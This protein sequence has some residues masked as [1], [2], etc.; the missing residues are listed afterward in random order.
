MGKKGIARVYRIVVESEV[1]DRYASAFEGMRMETRG[2]RT[3]LIGEDVDQPRLF[4]ILERLNGLGLK[5]LS[6]EALSEDVGPSGR[7]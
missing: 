3:I 5:L 4:G 2:G 7:R 6:V 1:G